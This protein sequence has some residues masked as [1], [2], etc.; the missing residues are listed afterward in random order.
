MSGPQDRVALQGMLD[1]ARAAR[2]Q[3]DIARAG[4]IISAA[5]SQYSHLEAAADGSDGLVLRGRLLHLSVEL[6]VLRR[7][8]DEA[9]RH[10]R[11]ALVLFEEAGDG[12]RQG[13]AWTDLANISILRGRHEET[14]RLFARALSLTEVPIRR[15]RILLNMAMAFRGQG[16][17]REA[18]QRM[19]DAST[20]FAEAGREREQIYALLNA[21]MIPAS[22]DDA[23]GLSEILGRL[24]RVGSVSHHPELHARYLMLRGVQSQLEGKA[25]S[26][27]RLLRKAIYINDES[28]QS[29]DLGIEIRAVLAQAIVRRGER[30]GR[31]ITILEE[32]LEQTPADSTRR[33]DVLRVLSGALQATGDLEASTRAFEEARDTFRKTPE[34]VMTHRLLVDRARMLLAAGGLNAPEAELQ[35]LIRD[36]RDVS[37]HLDEPGLSLEVDVL[38]AELWARIRPEDALPCIG[39]LQ[40]QLAQLRA[41]DPDLPAALGERLEQRLNSAWHRAESGVHNSL[42]RDAEAVEEIV[43]S[44]RAEDTRQQ[45]GR[46][47]DAIL[48]RVGGDR[49][50]LSLQ[51]GDQI[52]IVATTGLTEKDAE[53]LARGLLE[54]DAL[55]SGTPLLITNDFEGLVPCDSGPRTAMVFPIAVGGS[56]IG[57]LYVDRPSG[58]GNAA[59]FGAT[60]LRTFAFLANGLAAVSRIRLSRSSIEPAP[61]RNQ[62]QGAVRYDQLLFRS[63]GMQEVVETLEVVKDTDLSLLVLGE[64]GTGKELVAR[65]IH[66]GGQRAEGP[67]V[68]VNCAAVPRE[69]LEAEL[70]GYTRGAFTG[71]RTDKRG[72]FVEADGGTLFLDEIGEMAPDVQAKLLRALE[73]KIIYPVGGSKGIRV[74]FRIVA[75][76]NVQIESAVNA[77]TFRQDL[78]YRLNAVQVELPPLRERREDISLLVD[79]FLVDAIRD[80]PGELQVTSEAREALNQYDWPG[81]I[82]ELRNV[83]LTSAAFGRRA[84][85]V[86]DVSA[87]PQRIANQVSTRPVKLDTSMLLRLYGAIESAGYNQVMDELERFVLTE[88]VERSGGN[89]RAAARAVSLEESSIR[90]KLKRLAPDPAESR[91][92]V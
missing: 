63:P 55:T 64:S 52:D 77:G 12:P 6:H 66:S 1:A 67:F 82:R 90:T 9:E 88:A 34:V 41:G 22:V 81:N 10:A 2:A 15:A 32:L 25:D 58:N 56:T 30:P 27:T 4:G 74:N 3:G 43:R 19:L 35:A 14:A 23:P 57:M 54:G 78:Y 91:E 48:E 73:D 92:P 68:A 47:A 18:R 29:T 72:L 7:Q 49:A 84:G 51:S 38:E 33:A 87:L 11:N 70:F 50:V 89:R 59:A 40:R 16:R 65:A 86:I 76:T 39:A 83:V 36:A 13:M 71:A 45:L 5:L 80:F 31:A 69:L 62:L 8:L 26:A 17:L 75:A 79:H 85:G 24:R 46:F 21:A 20:G 53:G 60:D 61:L 42:T 28:L 44:L 37:Q